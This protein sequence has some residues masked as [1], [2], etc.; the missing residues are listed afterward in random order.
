MPGPAA[1][2]VPNFFIDSFRI[3]PFL[4]PIYQAAGIE[5]DVP[6]QVLAAI[7]E[8]ET[9]YGRNLSVSTAGAVGWMQF[10]PS[11][12]RQWGVDANGDGV[13]DP[14]NPVDAIFSAAR[15]LHAA[16]ASSDLPRAILAYNHADWY[17]QSVLVRAQLIGG[18]PS[19]LLGSLVGLVEGHFP[20]AAPAEYADDS[21]DALAGR[22]IRGSNAAIAID[23]TPGQRGTAIFARRGS[24][25]IA[26]ND[27]RIVKLGS[28]P[29]LG[30]YVELEDATGNVYTYAHLGSTS[31]RYPVPKAVRPRAPKVLR[32]F[33]IPA[34]KAPT[35]PASAGSQARAAPALASAGARARGRGGLTAA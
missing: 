2:G 9:D 19:Q 22:R 10:L 23:S 20:V 16:G 28:S 26:V 17:V 12:W 29:Q 14:Y 15:Y 6:W 33:S 8:I 32:E 3:P 5:Y 7:N 21:V 25:V 1:V 11:T 27:G 30:R 35:A 18:I 34:A 24:P 4:I 31:R 13:A